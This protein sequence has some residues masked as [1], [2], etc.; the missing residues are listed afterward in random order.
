M[1]IEHKMPQQ[2]H[3]NSGNSISRLTSILSHT[4]LAK[5]SNIYPC[6][7]IKLQKQ[8]VRGIEV[9]VEI[10]LTCTLYGDSQPGLFTPR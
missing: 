7:S 1:N 9:E 2:N 8:V 5:G 10:F 3:I 6:L 4:I